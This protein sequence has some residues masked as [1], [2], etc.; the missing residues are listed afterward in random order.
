[1]IEN[2]Q[3]EVTWLYWVFWIHVLWKSRS[4]FFQYTLKQIKL[5]SSA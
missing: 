2:C 4:H 1:M 3:I 5:I